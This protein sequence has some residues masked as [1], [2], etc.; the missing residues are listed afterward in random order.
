METNENKKKTSNVVDELRKNLYQL[1]GYECPEEPLYMNENAVAIKKQSA[2]DIEK[3]IHYIENNPEKYMGEEKTTDLH[4]HI[5]GTVDS[6]QETFVEALNRIGFD[7]KI[8]SNEKATPSDIDNLLSG[9]YS[10]YELPDALEFLLSVSI[11]A[12]FS[13]T[14]SFDVYKDTMEHLEK[15]FSLVLDEFCIIQEKRYEYLQEQLKK[16]DAETEKD[17][18]EFMKTILPSLY[19]IPTHKL[20][21]EL[22]KNMLN[23]G[24]IPIKLGKNVI[25]YNELSSE[26]SSE[27]ECKKPNMKLSNPDEYTAYDVVVQD[28]IISLYVAGNECFTPEAVYRTMTG[29][30]GDYY[31]QKIS[32]DAIDKIVESIEKMRRIRL[33]ID[34]SQE[35]AER[36][37]NITSY[38]MDDMLLSLKRIRMKTSGQLGGTKITAYKFNSAPILYDYIQKVSKQIAT[39]PIQRLQTK[40]AVRNTDSVIKIREYLIKRIELLKNKH[41][42]ICNPHI[43]YDR[44]F[45]ECQIDAS[46]NKQSIRYK[47]QIGKILDVFVQQNYIKG[48]Q[49]YKSGKRKVGVKVD[50]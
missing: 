15:I 48:Y 46:D 7:I 37:V 13:V 25:T 17:E 10:L 31:T 8:L 11:K 50:Y 43:T 45:K 5:I 27:L 29:A 20:A 2:K 24:E 42:N 47:E 12:L 41:N 32:D 22:P 39:V 28:A 6:E 26:Y 35:A 9:E 44:I 38:K 21:G 18:L 34:F 1:H 33:T 14:Q 4:S 19:I 23:N 30:T 36:N 3:S 16:Y 49:E 40:K